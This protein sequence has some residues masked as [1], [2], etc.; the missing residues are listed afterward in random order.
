M[1]TRRNYAIERGNL[2]LD[3]GGPV[4]SIGDHQEMLL[5]DNDEQISR[6][7]EK[8]SAIREISEQISIEI[9]RSSKVIGQVEEE[10]NSAEGLLATA[11]QKLTYLAS[12]GSS[13]HICYLV[14]FVVFMFIVLYF[15]ITRT[16]RS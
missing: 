2:G 8:T 13:R 16:G 7:H 4:G 10:M 3:N 5:R 12:A 15:V 6:L 14:T 9:G 11:M 1:T